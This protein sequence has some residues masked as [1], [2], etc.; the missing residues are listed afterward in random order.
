MKIMVFA[1]V[2][3]RPHITNIFNLGIQRLKKDF[4]VSVT[5]ATSTPEDAVLCHSFGYS[6]IGVDNSPLGNKHNVGIAKALEQDFDYLMIMGSDD[7]I[8]NKGVHELVNARKNYVGYRSMFAYDTENAENYH[9]EYEIDDFIIGAGRVL[10]RECVESVHFRSAFKQ[11]YKGHKHRVE[12]LISYLP[13]KTAKQLQ[14]RGVGKKWY[15]VIGMYDSHLERSLDGSS[16]KNILLS[17]FSRSVLE[18]E[19]PQI[20]D[21]KS[22]FNINQVGG[23]HVNGPSKFQKVGITLEEIPYLSAI[24]KAEIRKLK[25]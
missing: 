24:E 19:I 17:G 5:V 20:I 4:N 15:D 12:E 7:L 1:A 21:L 13:T 14:E 23:L 10:S 3:G 18:C 11:R 22:E 6:V 8:S 2:Y 9:F 25:K 16:D